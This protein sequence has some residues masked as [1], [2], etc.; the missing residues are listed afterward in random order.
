ML[1]L[2]KLEAMEC[3]FPQSYEAVRQR[4]GPISRRT[5]YFD[6]GPSLPPAAAAAQQHLRQWAH[7]QAVW[8]TRFQNEW[9]TCSDQHNNKALKKYGG[10]RGA[11]IG[12]QRDVVAFV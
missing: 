6:A 1:S 10:A 5:K 12:L 3:R 8:R 2:T 7:Y 11:A 4:Q 9:Q